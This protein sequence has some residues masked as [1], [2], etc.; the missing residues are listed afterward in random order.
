MRRSVT[1]ALIRLIGPVL[2]V[3]VIAGIEDRGAVLRAIASASPGPL[4]LA[5]LLNLVNIH[6]KVIRWGALLRVRGIRYPVRRAWAS[7]LTSLYVGMLTPGRVGDVLRI[8]YLRHDLGTPYAEG[9]AS[10]VMD[11]LC[12]LYVL[13]AFVAVGVA[14]YSEVIAGRLAWITWGGIAVTVL[15]PLLLLIPG[16][17][18][19]GARALLR[20]L[21]SVDP[22][23]APLFFEALRAQVGRPLLATIPLTVATFV[24]N[25]VQGYLIARSLGLPIT[26]FDSMCLLAVASLLGL[27]PVSISGV[28]VRELF[29]SLVFPVL[30]HPPEAGVTF[31]LLVFAV[32]YLA[33]AALGFV[34]WQIAP[35]PSAPPEGGERS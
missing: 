4:G 19:A 5:L 35:P 16:L 14:R 34:S 22:R 25:Y 3:L 28:G 15:L 2:L 1:R 17:A 12:D 23:G 13:A 11:R 20:R 31:G 32:I 24:V 7:F 9:L 33:I 26:L 8:R 27:L 18:D 30:G 6:L 29:F 10:V 21:P